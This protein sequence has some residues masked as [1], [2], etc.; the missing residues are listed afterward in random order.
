MGEKTPQGW[1]QTRGWLRAALARH[2]LL[3]VN[4]G[5]SVG[6]SGLG[7]LLQQRIE[8]GRQTP[9]SSASLATRRSPPSSVN[10][11]RTVNMSTSFG[12]TAGVLCHHWYRVLDNFLPGRTLRTIVV[13]IA[14]DQVLF[15]PICIAACIFVSGAVF[16]AKSPSQ[17]VKD[18]RELGTQLWLSEWFIWPPAQ[19]VN[20]YFLPTKYRVIYDNLV[21]L[22]Y[23]WYTS[24]LKHNKA[25]AEGPT[26]QS[27]QPL[28]DQ[29]EGLR[30]VL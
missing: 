24:H 22:F 18:A 6:L 4:C 25:T 30:S 16:E 12:L 14:W 1:S 10:W 15:S 21:S 11:K 3:F 9:R 26:G 29:S 20:F 5:V 13:K 28:E 8:Q 2:Q 23:D 19:F 7:D 17:I 27:S